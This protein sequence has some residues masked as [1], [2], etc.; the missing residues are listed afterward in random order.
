LAEERIVLQVFKNRP[1]LFL[2]VN[3]ELRSAGPVRVLQ[4]GAC[5]AVRE[6]FRASNTKTKPFPW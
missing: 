2:L 4:S 3:L 1:P 6:F 5:K